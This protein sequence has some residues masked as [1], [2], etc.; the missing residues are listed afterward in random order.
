MPETQPEKSIRQRIISWEGLVFGAIALVMVGVAAFVIFQPIK[1]LPRMQLAPGYALT[2]ERAERLTNEDLRGQFVMYNFTY[3]GCR[4][5]ECQQ[6]DLAMKELQE[7]LDEAETGSTP[8]SFVTISFDPER[9]TP[10]VLQAYAEELG[11]DTDQWHFVSGDPNKLKSII[12]SGFLVYYNQEE[13]GS[14]QFT[15][16]MALVDGWGIVRGI[17]NARNRPVDVDDMIEHLSGMQREVE[18]SDDVGRL[19]Y[20]AAHLFLCYY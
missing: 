4:D 2:D 10:E 14:W 3:S 6:L 12:G 5:P 18:A 1:V 7:R 20:E 15:P 16:T 17:Y 13:D 19:G 11:A 8:V 9:D